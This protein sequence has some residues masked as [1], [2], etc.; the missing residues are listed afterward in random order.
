MS[1]SSLREI[2]H[3]LH[4]QLTTCN[5]LED[6][7][8]GDR[9]IAEHNTLYRKIYKER[10]TSKLIMRFMRYGATY[11]Y[12][13]GNESKK[14]MFGVSRCWILCR[15]GHSLSRLLRETMK[16]HMFR[17]G[18]L[19]TGEQYE[20]IAISYI[21]RSGRRQVYR[22]DMLVNKYLPFI[23]AKP[24]GIVVKGGNIIALLEV[25]SI[26]R[27]DNY[28]E[29]NGCVYW[30]KNHLELRRNSPQYLQ[31]QLSLLITGLPKCFLA[32]VLPRRHEDKCRTFIVYKDYEYL[33]K[34]MN[35]I[36]HTFENNVIPILERNPLVKRK[37]FNQE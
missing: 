19:N 16:P 11:T 37:I 8:M 10:Y 12:E 26:S 28:E 31:V 9:I 35:M 24:D 30:R 32:V 15:K 6:I 18:Y 25:K 13:F 14:I 33:K 1:S 7:D 4:E 23:C 5:P 27:V 22:P 17:S 29:L 2:E 20:S 36:I 3:S 34:H 21:E